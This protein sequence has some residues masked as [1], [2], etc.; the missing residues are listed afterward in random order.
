MIEPDEVA[1]ISPE[2]EDK[3]VEVNLRRQTVQ[4]FENGR[5]VFF[6]R[7][8]TGLE[9]FETSPGLWHRIWRK[10]IS[11]HMAGN[12]GVGYDTPGIGYTTLFIGEGI[13]FHATFWH[14]A[15]GQK[16]S[17]GCV[18][19]RPDDAKWI[20]RWTTPYVSAY[21]SPSPGDA[22]VSGTV[23]TIVRVVEY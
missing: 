12:T 3:A 16:W 8:S 19:L 10:M 17:H 4:A 7:C 6:A 1:P 18:N 5:E 11:T 22:T 9:E 13:A 21:E 2:V 20:W 15:Y 14:N 23:G